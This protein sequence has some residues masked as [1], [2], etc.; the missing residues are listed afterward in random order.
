MNR[1]GT[2]IRLITVK[3][4]DA[5][6]AHLGRDAHTMARW[7]PAR[8]RDYYTAAGQ[9]R[10]IERLLMQHHSGELW[11]GVIVAGDVVIG[12]ITVQEILRSAWRKASL[13]YW[14]ASTHHRQGH[15]TRAVGLLVELMARELGL[16]RAEAITQV[17]N[18]ASQGV[19]LKN[20]FTPVGTAH[21]HMF[22]E[23]AWHDEIMWERLLEDGS[24]PR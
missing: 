14:V 3:D 17:G 23:G 13:G 5:I 15:A 4:A 20:G 24:A 9:R 6:V 2:G 11:P 22:T 12:R 19:L 21:S 18:V 8:P 16:H 10:S 1:L 7:E